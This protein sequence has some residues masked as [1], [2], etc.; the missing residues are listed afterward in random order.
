MLSARELRAYY[1]TR[2]GDVR[3]VDGV[4][5][6]VETGMA[7]G[8]V[9][10]SGSGKSTLGMALT[11]L[12][13]P[14]LRV[15]GSVFF[16]GKDIYAMSLEELRAIRGIGLSLIPQFAMDALN[17]TARIKRLIEDLVN[18]HLDSVKFHPED[19]IRKAQERALQI[20]LPKWVLDRY[21]VELSGGMRQRVAILL[22]TIL[23]PEV[24][25]ADEPTSALD[26]VVQRLVIQYLQDLL[27]EGAIKSLIFIT[28]DIATAYQIATHMAVMYAGQIVEMGPAESITME[29]LHPYTRGLMSSIVEPGMNIKKVK[30]EGL[31]G[32]PPDLLNP[33]KGC[34]F[35]SRCKY[36]MDIC[37]DHD[38]PEVNIGKVKVKCWLYAEKKTSEVK[39]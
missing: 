34:R 24:L 37:K 7:L 12:V 31:T 29:P 2:Y 17:P 21:P 18:S 26:V 10:E 14:P 9:G 38:P 39:P 1:K 4:D 15:K 22:S 11:A 27:K 33:P 5:F 36:R 13:K 35:Y 20:G 16:K 32:E 19:V 28:H 8:V 23:D 3:A 6:D 30:L 25:V